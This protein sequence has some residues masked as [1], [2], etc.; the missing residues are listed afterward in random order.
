M[1]LFVLPVALI[2]W[3]VRKG[4][5]DG[6]TTPIGQPRKTEPQRTIATAAQPPSLFAGYA[7]IDFETT[8]FAD[9]DKVVEIGMVLTDAQGKP[10]E[11]WTT[12]VNPKRK[13]PARVSAIHGIT[14]KHVQGAPTF[15][16]VA[17]VLAQKLQGRVLV[18]HNA[19]FDK[20]FLDNE[21]RRAGIDVR[22]LPTICTMKLSRQFLKPASGKLA[23][24]LAVAGIKNKKAHS[25][26][27]DAEA[28][29][30]LFRVIVR[31]TN[32]RPWQSE[33]RRAAMGQ[34]IRYMTAAEMP[35][36][37][38][39]KRDECLAFV[40]PKCGAEVGDPCVG[41][42]TYHRVRLENRD[43]VALAA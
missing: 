16:D 3:A 39:L 22:E 36:P 2:I 37:K 1:L 40:C 21:M 14:D 41:V 15:Q 38:V 27:A 12:R 31:K 35:V 9:Y 25:A 8:G 29:A 20:R 6:W 33:V 18:A 19:S 28:T 32:Q 11:T 5:R 17:P 42:S 43:T 34:S 26:G 30:E 24:C 13:I 23:D 7:V 4:R 10:Q